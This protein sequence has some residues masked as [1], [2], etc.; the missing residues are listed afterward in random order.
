MERFLKIYLQGADP[1]GL[2][3]IDVD[4]Y[5]DRYLLTYTFLTFMNEYEVKNIDICRF[6]NHIREILD[7]DEDWISLDEESALNPLYSSLAIT[8]TH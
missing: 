8:R 3:A 5:K 1:Y 4:R 2:S 6:V 7:V